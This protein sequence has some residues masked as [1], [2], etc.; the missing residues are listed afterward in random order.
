MPNS[1]NCSTIPPVKK[2]TIS[3]LILL[4]C[5]L[6]ILTLAACSPVAASGEAEPST[7]VP[8]SP[9]PTAT[10]SPPP[11]LAPPATPT[12]APTA[13]ATYT[14]TPAPPQFSNPPDEA[15]AQTAVAHN[16]ELLRPEPANTGLWQYAAN[17]FIH[18]L[19]L[20]VHQDTAYLLDG[21]RV[22]ALDLARPA[23]PELLLSPGD[24]AAGVTVI[25]P[26]DLF[27]AP[28]GL[29]VLDRAGDV[30]RRDWDTAA[31]S[32]E[33]DDRP[34]GDTSSHYYVALD[35][36][37]D[38]RF[39]LE[40]SYKYVMD[41][42]DGQQQALWMLP[43][44]RAVDVA[45]APGADD[46][47]NVYVLLQALDSDAGSLRLYR[48]TASVTS[49]RPPEI[50]TQPRQVVAADTAVYVL[51][52]NGRRLLVFAPD[53]GRLQQI[54]Q[55]PAAVSA[56]GQ[57]PDGALLLAGRDR[58]YFP[59]QP[60]R[61]AAISGGPQLVGPQPHDPA[62]LAAIGGF[63]S[64]I[65]P[66]VS[67]RDLQMPGAPRH[68]RLGV[69]QGSDFYWSLGSPVYAVADGTVIRA[70]HDYTPPFPAEFF[71]WQAEAQQ[72]GYTS[73]EALDFYRGRQVWIQHANGLVSRYVHLDSIDYRIQEGQPVT[74][75]QLIGTVGNSGS[76]GS[77]ESE[78][79]DVHLHFEL[80]LGDHY[81]GQFLRPVETRYW[82]ERILLGRAP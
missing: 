67:P 4:A 76:P 26:L 15:L 60:L 56:I 47:P 53:N 66:N 5:L 40:T 44:A 34:I 29:L 23:A 16:A 7:A 1:V 39:L 74:Q 18:P 2:Q 55:L 46:I 69:H 80:W 81:L 31:W 79:S 35:G 78:D 17:T 73:E 36:Q 42:V 54:W 27:V 22:L 58:L 33:R 13:V 82:I 51:D 21:G 6:A 50:I 45:A 77:L 52:E 57:T 24:V 8:P 41:Y 68:Y 65:G 64:P 62:F 48:D 75:G 3:S 32:L 72:L 11:T 28:D 63:S 20:V 59:N 12:A 71:A 30:Y 14:P 10:A 37:A 25:E 49:F 70:M 43:E 9:S 38:G 61:L 19:A